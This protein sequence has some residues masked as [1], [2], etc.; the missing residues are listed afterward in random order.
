LRSALREFERDRASDAATGPGDECM[1]AREVD[2][3]HRA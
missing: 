2:L 3:F 1:T